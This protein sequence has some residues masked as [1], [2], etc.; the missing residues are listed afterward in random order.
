[1][2]IQILPE[3]LGG[4]YVP[5]A[6]AR[7]LTTRPAALDANVVDAT[8]ATVGQTTDEFV[9]RQALVHEIAACGRTATWADLAARHGFSTST[10][11]WLWQRY[12][13]GGDAAIEPETRT[14]EGFR[15]FERE[16]LRDARGQVLLSPVAQRPVRRVASGESHAALAAEIEHRWS[17]LGKVNKRRRG[18]R[19]AART[20]TA[21]LD[22]LGPYLERNGLFIEYRTLARYVKRYLRNDPQAIAARAGKRYYPSSSGRPEQLRDITDLLQVVCVDST[23]ADLLCVSNDGLTVLQRGW[24]LYAFDVRSRALWSWLITRRQPSAHHYL[25][26]FERGVLPKD[27][28]CARRGT[29]NRYPVHGIPQL[30]L[31]D[32]GMAEAAENVRFK[33]LGLQVIVEHAPPLLPQMKGH[34]ER[35]AGTVSRGLLHRLPG[36]TLSNPLQ[37]GGHDAVCEALRYGITFDR[38]EA[39]F[40]RAIIDGF[41]DTLHSSLGRTPI[42]EW[43][44]VA[45]MRR[46]PREW[47]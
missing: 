39:N 45:A 42:E 15:V 18:P 28:I 41:M 43:E 17:N 24:I 4:Q 36:T 46:G 20:V 6:D 34:V 3:I 40:D 31:A 7:Y 12:V 13:S 38:F 21:L 26:L 47:S 9:R 32:R 33:A 8:L 19:D 1:M 23:V 10:A 30:I 35:I 14:S 25:R 44:R 37:R 11:H 22:E 5:D 16:P 27:E 2:T 29:V